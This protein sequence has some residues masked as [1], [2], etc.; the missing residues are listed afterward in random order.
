MASR[1]AATAQDRGLLHDEGVPPSSGEPSGEGSGHNGWSGDRS[2]IGPAYDDGSGA[3]TA[4]DGG[5]DA[6]E[7]SGGAT[8]DGLGWAR[9]WAPVGQS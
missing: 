7:W 9:G 5:P 8:L 1:A 3:G 4:Y 6:G 2:G